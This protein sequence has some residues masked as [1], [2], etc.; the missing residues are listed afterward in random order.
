VPAP[1]AERDIAWLRLE[2]TG[3]GPGL[4]EQ[5]VYIQRLETR[6]GVAPTGSCQAGASVAVQ[7]T[8]TYRFR[9]PTNA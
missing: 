4:F 9:A 5:V 1:P 7:D 8:A 3:T 6:G 2:T